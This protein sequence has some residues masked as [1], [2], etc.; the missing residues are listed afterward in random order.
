[1]GS[2]T[3]RFSKV[4]SPADGEITTER[5]AVREW[6][7]QLRGRVE[8]LHRV[9][10]RNSLPYR[11]RE[12]PGGIGYR[13][14]EL[15]P[16]G[17]LVFSATA[18]LTAT[19]GYFLE[20]ISRKAYNRAGATRNQGQTMALDAGL[21]AT[22]ATKVEPGG[23]T[24]AFANLVDPDATSIIHG[25]L[26]L[27]LADAGDNVGVSTMIGGFANQCLVGKSS[28]NV[29]IDQVTTTDVTNRTQVEG[30]SGS[31]VTGR[32]M[33]AF[34]APGSSGALGK[35]VFDGSSGYIMP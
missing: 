25:W 31:R 22:E 20:P 28:G 29:T 1:M 35:V 34:T 9:L 4:W 21:T 18:S 13:L 33:E 26:V 24:S 12:T 5:T 19:D 32:T 16:A 27:L 11:I 7:T 6:L 10:K 3:K 14:N 17:R 15:I 2:F 30:V 23:E 8:R